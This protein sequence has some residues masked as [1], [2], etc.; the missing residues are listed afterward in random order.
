MKNDYYFKDATDAVRGP[1]PFQRIRD[2]V[3]EGLLPEN[4]QVA[5]KPTGPWWPQTV[6]KANFLTTMCRKRTVVDIVQ[7]L[8]AWYV[9]LGLFELARLAMD[10]FSGKLSPELVLRGGLVGDIFTKA[11]AAFVV[12]E[13]LRRL[14]QITILLRARIEAQTKAP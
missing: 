6:V 7:L 11:L 10:S 12:S 1:I 5:I 8:G 14:Y 13:V 2:E 3:G 4:T 9:A